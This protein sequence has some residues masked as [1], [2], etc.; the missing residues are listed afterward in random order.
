[1]HRDGSDVN[2]KK[3]CP[4]I[5]GNECMA[6]ECMFFDAEHEECEL[7][8]AVIDIASEGAMERIAAARED[9]RGRR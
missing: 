1:M 7:R 3:R 2:M 9:G 5:G 8:R 4:F 6:E